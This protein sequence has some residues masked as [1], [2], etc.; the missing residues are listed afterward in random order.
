MESTNTEQNRQEL[1]NIFMSTEGIQAEL[2]ALRDNLDLD[3]R[4]LDDLKR[5]AELRKSIGF[6]KEDEECYLTV[7][8]VLLKFMPSLLLEVGQEQP[9]KTDG[10]VD[11]LKNKSHISLRKR[12]QTGNYYEI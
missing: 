3:Q 5:S 4:V 12:L 6:S 9:F 2:D 1:E 8:E 10:A 7:P 11:E